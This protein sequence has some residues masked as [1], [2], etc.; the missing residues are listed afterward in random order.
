MKAG[1]IMY[2]LGVVTLAAVLVMSGVVLGQSFPIYLP[3]GP[4]VTALNNPSIADVASVQASYS[5]S[6][7]IGPTSSSPLLVYLPSTTWLGYYSDGNYHA[8][9]NFTV[10]VYNPGV[11]TGSVTI[12]VSCPPPLGTGSASGTVPGGTTKSFNITLRANV[13]ETYYQYS[14]QAQPMVCQVYTNLSTNNVTAVTVQV[15]VVASS[16]DIDEY[17]NMYYP[18]VL[19]AS[20]HRTS[21]T[22]A[23]LTYRHQ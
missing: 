8:A 23:R 19:Y 13:N 22:Q 12:Y 6:S 5:W 18:D 21:T 9:V 3:G 7:P 16:Y 4:V 1:S 15:P 2:I 11:D 14:G 20:R 17:N 10:S